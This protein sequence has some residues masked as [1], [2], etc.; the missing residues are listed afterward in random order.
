MSRW[1]TGHSNFDEGEEIMSLSKFVKLIAASGAIAALLSCSLQGG[2]GGPGEGARG[3]DATSTVGVSPVLGVGDKALDD[4]KQVALD[5]LNT[6]RSLSSPGVNT[7]DP[8]CNTQT[9]GDATK[10][11]SEKAS[12]SG[13]PL[14]ESQKDELRQYVRAQCSK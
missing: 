3:G 11:G 13:K 10:T 8:A 9:Q 12:V 14:T 5:Y 2:A 1:K 7:Q 6:K 4:A